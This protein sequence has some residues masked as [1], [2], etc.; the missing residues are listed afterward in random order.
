MSG[1]DGHRA[2]APYLDPEIHA[3]LADLPDLV[4]DAETLPV[5]RQLL[6]AAA[7]PSADM[8]RA[9]HPVGD[10]VVVSV[11]RPKHLAVPTAC[12]YWIHGGGMIIGD[13]HMDNAQLERWCRTF[14]CVCVSVEYRLAPEHRFPVALE[15]C[16][17]GL[18]WVGDH[19]DALGV[20][21]GR[22]GMGGLSAG[23]GLAAATA[24]HARDQ[25]GPDLRCL[26][27]DCPMLDD[28]QRTPSSRQDG[29]AVWS[30]DANEFGWRS[31]LGDRYGTDD[32][33]ALAAPARATDLSGLPP[34]YLAVGTADGFRDECIE[35]ALRLNQAAVPTELHVYPGVPHGTG[36]FAPAPMALRIARDLDEFVGRWLGPAPAAM[37]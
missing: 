6:P 2:S 7:D 4:F 9:D 1:T 20:D 8:E 36:L 24:L 33:P 11:T 18:R 15:D 5:A 31:Y 16:A 22:I 26:V 28:R 13:R 29:L 35:F 17:A 32:V 23:G 25:G 14:G 12:M 21:P 3:V 30:R 10:V 37:P 27:L 19:A 34:T